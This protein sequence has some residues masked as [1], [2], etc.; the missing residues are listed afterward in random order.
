MLAAILKAV[1]DA[2]HT[3]LELYDDLPG[4]LAPLET[5]R[6]IQGANNEVARDVLARTLALANRRFAWRTGYDR[7]TSK[8]Y[9]TILLVGSRAAVPIATTPMP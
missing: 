1:A 9:V 7:V 3:H 2:N 6:A 4:P 5:I 8:Y